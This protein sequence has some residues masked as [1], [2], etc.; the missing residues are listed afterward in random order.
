[1][2]GEGAG[3]EGGEEVMEEERVGR[4]ERVPGRGVRAGRRTPSGA[5][6]GALPAAPG[7]AASPGPCPEAPA[8]L[9]PREGFGVTGL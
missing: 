5:V 3:Q 6:V 8:L 2:R 1:M 7:R 9:L 4:E